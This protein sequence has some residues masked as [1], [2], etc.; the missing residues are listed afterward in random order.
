MKAITLSGFGGPDVL[1]YRDVP[2]PVA[3]AGQVLIRV[4][5]TSVNRPDI[6]Q[7]EGN[8]PPPPGDSEILGLDVAGIV[9]SVGEGVTQIRSGLRVAALV[10]GG[11]YAEYALAYAN[12]CIELPESVSFELGA[13][14]CET[15]ITAYLNT[16]MLGE[17]QDGEAVLL[18]GG[19]GGVNTAAIQICRVLRPDSTLFVT[20][21]SGKLERVAALGV[22]HIIDYQQTNFDD[23]IKN[24]TNK[25]GVDVIL[26]HLG[27]SYLRQNLRCLAINGRLV[28]IGVTGGSTADVN[29][30][31]LMI[32]R[33]RIL[34]SVLR[35]RPIDEKARIIDTFATAILPHLE[36]GAIKP[37][38]SDVYPLSEAA[39]A[40][41]TMEA[42]QH[43]GK[44]VL[45]V[46]S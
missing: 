10:G 29:L 17:L 41:N 21:S 24:L 5:A 25:Q 28:I 16:L 20:A 38:V 2:V 26:D 9:E 42:S 37:L 22:H 4:I 15:Y 3:G 18:H 36:S 19:G 40:H 14:L 31:L 45:R 12:H 6:V 13:C 30:A 44:I 23:E 46:G 1:Q 34:G 33:Q 7:R 43:F 35:S 39:K 11:G 27:A 32:K 8:Y